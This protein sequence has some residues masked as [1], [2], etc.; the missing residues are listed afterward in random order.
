MKDL[1]N[2]LLDFFNTYGESFAM[3]L[4]AGF[5]I[6]AIVELGVKNA[7]EWLEDQLGKKT[8]LTIARIA[9]ITLVT[10]LG[11]LISTKIITNGSLPLPGNSAFAVFWFFII[12]GSQYVFSMYGIKA[13]LRIKDKKK[14][15]KAPKEPKPKKAKP[16]DGM[17][18]IAHN[19]Y[20]AA[21][22]KLYNR[23]GVELV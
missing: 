14:E 20:K 11:S 5:I 16:T 12:Y 22:G 17:T 2:I 19:V 1:V 8:Y 10:V 4:L 7:F 23:K 3:M 18:K 9:V 15:P 21:D 6:A 13:M